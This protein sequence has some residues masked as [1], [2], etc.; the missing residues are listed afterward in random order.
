R[1]LLR[2]AD[3]VEQHGEELRLLDVVEMGSPIGR[4][5]KFGI[6]RAAATLR[7]YAGWATKIHGETVQNSVAHSMVTYT[8]KE[9]VG[10]VGAIIPWNGPVNSAI[11][12]IAPVLATGCTMV[13]KPAEEAALTPLRLG[14]LIG[15]LDLPPGV[16][17]IVTGF[18]ETAGA[19]LAAHPGVDKV[20]F[21]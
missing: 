20:A 13:L 12:K 21:T 11:W 4:N 14:E 3:L 6:A 1:A 16:V 5:P 19:A 10:V 8:L 18:G 9:P 15:E 2:L 7:Y 17:N